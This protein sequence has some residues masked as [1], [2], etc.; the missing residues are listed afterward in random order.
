MCIPDCPDEC[1]APPVKSGRTLF[2]RPGTLVGEEE[3][4]THRFDCNTVGPIPV[5]SGYG[6]R[7]LTYSAAYVLEGSKDHASSLL[8]EVN[9][10]KVNVT[11]IVESIDSGTQITTFTGSDFHL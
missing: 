10:P 4:V 2:L 1:T 6:S 3:S 5:A 9:S 7:T 11:P 8:C